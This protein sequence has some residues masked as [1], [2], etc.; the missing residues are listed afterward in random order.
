MWAFLA[1]EKNFFDGCCSEHCSTLA[2]VNTDLLTFSDIEKIMIQEWITY[3][4]KLT[5]VYFLVIP[6]YQKWLQDSFLRAD[7]LYKWDSWSQFLFLML[8]LSHLNVCPSCFLLFF[9]WVFLVECKWFTSNCT[10]IYVLQSKHLPNPCHFF[11]VLC[12]CS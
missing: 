10:L 2:Q 8:C 11:E 4:V 5:F 9:L 6:V 12:F 1:L 3:Q 7:M